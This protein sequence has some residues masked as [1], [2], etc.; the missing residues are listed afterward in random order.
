MNEFRSYLT[1]HLRVWPPNMAVVRAL[2]SVH[3]KHIINLRS[4]SLDLG[5]GDGKFV[6]IVFGKF[7]IGIDISS[8]EI[9]RA[10]KIGSFSEVHC[11]DAHNIPYPDD[12]FKTI[13]SNCVIEHVTR[14][15]ALIQEIARV[16]NEKGEF[17]FT[18]W[19][20]AF[21]ESLLI[22]KKWYIRW[23]NN[24][25]NHVSIKSAQEW[26]EILQKHK[27]QVIHTNYYL[28]C[29]KLKYL[30]FLELVS[31]IG[32]WKLKIINVYRIIAPLIPSF[33]IN[34]FAAFLDN[35]FIKNQCDDR[36]CAMIIR[37]T[38]KIH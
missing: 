11:R 18:T 13:L 20:P 24:M 4:P 23:K 37:A 9:K 10:Q 28:D 29:R 27:L 15:E 36:G 26:E 32:F 25:L 12:Y 1:K 38:K 7:D 31:L 19:T 6:S 35:F 30:D 16:L 3:I 2:E 17:I 21:N 22:N 5:C 14:P 34:K 8:K 33:L